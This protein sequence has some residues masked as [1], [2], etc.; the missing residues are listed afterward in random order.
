MN[1]V[2]RLRSVSS[3]RNGP[4]QDQFYPDS[5]NSGPL[6]LILEAERDRWFVWVPVAF[7]AGIAV[8][9]ALPQEPSLITCL[10]PACAA[11][12][13]R[14]VWRQ[15]L[16]A[17]LLGGLFLM[18]ALG[19]TAAKLRTEWVR[20]PVLERPLRFVEVRGWLEHVEARQ[21]KGARLTIR[22]AT[23]GSL[24][25]AQ[26][27]RRVRITTHDRD[28][29]L[30]AG[31]AIKV[32]ASLTPPPR[33]VLPGG[34][35]FARRAWFLGLG[36]IGFARQRVE[37]DSGIGQ[38]PL[39]LRI[40][41]MVQ[42]VRQRISERIAR[43][44]PGETGGIATALIT[45]ERGGISTTTLEAFRSAGLVHVLAISGL[46][47]SIMAGTVFLIVRLLF[48]GVARN[49]AQTPNQEM[50]SRCCHD[51]RPHVSAGIRRVLFHAAGVHHDLHHVCSRPTQSTRHRVAQCRPHRRR[52]ADRISRKSV[53][54]QLSD[55]ICR[56]RGAGFIL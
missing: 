35:D 54:Y 46:H 49:C 24:A 47:M 31:I 22:V 55:V 10:V 23:L 3:G 9:F 16:G 33:P 43:A 50:G 2:D 18:A 14:F 32:R 56:C 15:G 51:R 7:G 25:A 30:H 29:R 40:G 11:S 44:L 8:Y 17:C 39:A 20:A 12:A 21:P 19:L 5:I 34:Y 38:A 27:P 52:S 36:A 53:R 45:G 4:D 42:R 13:S 37:I 41:A 28:P 48:C 1:F 6:A 26:R